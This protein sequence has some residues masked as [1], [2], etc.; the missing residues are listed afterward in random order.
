M[1]KVVHFEIPFDDKEKSIEFYKKVFGWKMKDMPEMNYTIAHTV[2]V[3]ENMMPKEHGAIN[4]GMYKRGDGSAKSPVIVIDVDDIDTKIKEVEEAGG[5]VFR[6]KVNV[7][8]MG[9]YTQVKDTEG[10]IIGLW[11]NIK[12]DN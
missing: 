6:A 2:E 10:N 9:F 7:G 3:D 5:S 1:N 4:G 11:E 12:K 8:K